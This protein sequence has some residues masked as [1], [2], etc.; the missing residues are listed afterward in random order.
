MATKQGW[1]LW[2]L[3]IIVVGAIVIGGALTMQRQTTSEDYPPPTRD[4]EIIEL[5]TEDEVRAFAK[6]L[7]CFKILLNRDFRKQHPEAY[8]FCDGVTDIWSQ[9]YETRRAD[10][11]L[12]WDLF[13]SLPE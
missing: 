10:R 6:H 9:K 4:L 13:N 2:G 1:V 5:W 8:A 7:G 11:K 12:N 3:T